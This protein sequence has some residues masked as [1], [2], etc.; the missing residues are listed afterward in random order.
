MVITI[1][2]TRVE[3]DMVPALLAAYQNGFTHLPPGLIRTFLA[4]SAE[5][6]TIWRMISVWESREALEEMRRSRAT[7]EGIL[8]FRAAGAEDPT[9]SIFEVAAYAP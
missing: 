9:L 2:E 7:P 8:M 1:L 4:H 3:P 6:K 5:D